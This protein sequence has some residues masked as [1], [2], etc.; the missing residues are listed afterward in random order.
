MY[1]TLDNN[2]CN[3]NNGGCDHVCTNTPGSFQCSCRDGYRL[4]SNGQ[5]CTGRCCHYNIVPS[6]IKFLTLECSVN[7]G[8]CEHICSNTLGSFRCS[9]RN[10]YQLASNGQ[11]CNGKNCHYNI[12][13]PPKCDNHGF[14]FSYRRMQYQQWW[15]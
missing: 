14:H 13:I 11:T 5:T 1:L 4:A 3:I 2:E 8:G 7:N 10:G 12:I 9:C 6:V 15:L